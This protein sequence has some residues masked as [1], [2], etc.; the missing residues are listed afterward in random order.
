MKFYKAEE[1][2]PACKDVF[3]KYALEIAALLPDAVIE[4]VGASSI[5][6]AV[7]KGDLDILVGVDGS[8]LEGAVKLL[9]TLGFKEKT[10]TLRTPELCMLESYSGEDVA[11][12]VVAHGPEF[13]MFVGFRNTLRENPELI[14]QYNQLKMSCEGW[15]HDDYRRTKSAFVERVLGQK[16]T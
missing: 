12:Q 7:S 1:Y 16:N 3:C 8:E 15:S 5:P 11:F 14:H 4:H 6:N 2:Q 13:E 9:S 10:D